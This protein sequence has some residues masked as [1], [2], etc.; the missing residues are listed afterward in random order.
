MKKVICYLF[1]G[2]LILGIISD[3]RLDLGEVQIAMIILIFALP[4]LLAFILKRTKEQP[5]QENYFFGQSF[6]DMG[7]MGDMLDDWDDIRDQHSIFAVALLRFITCWAVKITMA[8]L[9]WAVMFTACIMTYILLMVVWIADKF[10]MIYHKLSVACPNPDCQ[11]KFTLP[12]YQCDRCNAMH[13][14]LTPGRYGILRRKCECGNKLPST[15]FNGRG[16]LTAFCP[17]CNRSISGETAVKQYA[18]PVVGAPS[19]G[20]TC[21]I[22]MTIHELIHTVA[23]KN[24][25]E[26]SFA[27][28]GEKK[29]HEYLMLAMDKGMTPEKTDMD[30]LNA[31]Q[32]LLKINKES[33]KRRVYFYD[34]AGEKYTQSGAVL[35]NQAFTY[36]NG[37]IFLIDPLS[38]YEIRNEMGAEFNKQKYGTS[39][40][41]FDDV[42]DIMLNNFETLLKLKSKSAVNT[43]FAVTINKCDIPIIEE[44]IGHDAAVRYLKDNPQLKTVTDAQSELCRQFLMQYS[45]GNFI[46]KIEKKFKNV[47]YFACSSLGHSERGNAFF[48]IDVEKPFLWIMSNSD[49]SIVVNEE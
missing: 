35:N 20:K 21:Y 19:V 44:K 8:C 2:L 46:K 27:D 3:G 16:A 24:N 33:I 31:F 38:I 42:L 39:D 14:R 15:F 9:Q 43:N 29:E 18:I 6:E 32:L 25:W 26:I 49:K 5:A 30:A 11:H 40:A 41:E 4:S 13:T 12:V 22:N 48:G 1:L 45:A 10:Y 36:I 34:L 47:K 7:R 17:K 28:K 23:P 37:L